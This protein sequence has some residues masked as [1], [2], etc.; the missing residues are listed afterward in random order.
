MTTA[1]TVLITGAAKRIGA[2]LARDLHN[3]GMNIVIHYNTSGPQAETLAAELNDIRP[4]S[5]FLLKADLLKTDS[6]DAIIAAAVSHTGRLDVLINNASM[7]YPTPVGKTT[8]KD[9]MEL[10]GTNLTAP[11][12]LA[13]AAV[14][15][16]Q[17]TSG[18]IINITDIH[19]TRPLKD[20]PVYS[21]AKAGL[22]MLTKALAKELGPAI[23][24]NA[25]S[26]GAILWPERL[27]EK[28]QQQ[29]LSRTIMKRMGKP[30]DIASA[31]RFL[32]TGADYIT[33][34]VIVVDGG[35]TFFAD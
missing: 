24:A 18:C 30:E 28:K 27:T 15:E 10:I 19:G 31:V 11:Y 17:Q 32:I 9:W 1:K 29:I 35:R 13:Q 3:H 22:I 12:F 33:G 14:G 6:Y 2:A 16:L 8:Q 26:P 34:Q 7:F 4:D 25:I 5:A 21:T 23:R 20:H